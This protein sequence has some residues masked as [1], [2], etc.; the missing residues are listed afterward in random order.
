MR[1]LSALKD[2]VDWGLCIGCGACYA[3]CDRGAVS[4]VKIESIGIQAKV[5]TKKCGECCECLR[6]CPGCGVNSL[7]VDRQFNYTP[8]SHPLVGPAASVYEGCASDPEIRYQASSG[9]AL[10][11]M[12]LYCLE[13][14]KTAFVLHTGMDAATPWENVTVR[15]FNRDDLLA[16]AGSRYT[17]S[18]PCDSL[19][20][21]EQSERPCLFIGRPCDAAAV[22]QIRKLKPELDKKLRLVLTFFCAGPPCSQGTKDLVASLGMNAGEVLSV[23]Y[24]GRGWPGRFTVRTRNGEEKSLSYEESWGQLANKHRS[25]RCHLCPDGLG[26]CADIS[27]GDAWNRYQQNGNPGLSLVLARTDRG[28][29]VITGAIASGFIS[30]KPATVQDVVDAQ[31]LVRRRQELH[32]RL[33]AMKSLMIPAPT[34]PGFHLK[35]AWQS[36]SHQT[37]FRTVAGTLRRLILRGL[38]HRNDPVRP[39]PSQVPA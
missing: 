9:G 1:R 16:H 39:K 13:V 27:C 4:L 30:L 15:S 28:A 12:A 7:E 20:L 38:W 33:W 19:R 18:S 8:L 6:F 23:R 11:A 31:G 35:E 21:I 26:E 3:Y 17:P 29:K 14:E 37:K 22:Q 5:D 2:V 25:M 34:F 10:T 36:C 24:R 32:G